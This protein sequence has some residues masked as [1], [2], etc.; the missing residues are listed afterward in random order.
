MIERISKRSL[1]AEAERLQAEE[2]CGRKT[3]IYNYEATRYEKC[4]ELGATYEGV[5]YS[6]GIIGNTGRLDKIIKYHKDTD[7][8]ETL[9]YTFYTE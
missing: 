6:A 2:I 1:R 3:N 7:T 9:G 5:A 8:W 4:K